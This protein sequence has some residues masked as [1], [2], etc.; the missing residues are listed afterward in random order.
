MEIGG[1]ICTAS[2]T[3]YTHNVICHTFIQS[4]S[5]VRPIESNN[6]IIARINTLRN[7]ATTCIGPSSITI[8]GVVCFHFWYETGA[9]NGSHTICRMWMMD[10]MQ[11][12]DGLHWIILLTEFRRFHNSNGKHIPMHFMRSYSAYKIHT[13]THT[14]TQMYACMA[15]ISKYSHRSNLRGDDTQ[16]KTQNNCRNHRKLLCNRQQRVSV[17]IECL[18][19]CL[20]CELYSQ[21]WQMYQFHKSYA[22]SIL[23]K[24]E[25]CLA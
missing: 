11:W 13:H 9:Y 18:Y 17:W 19:M 5:N 22:N 16:K 3:R 1:S 2:T 12:V 4:I 7:N 10:R 23:P 15:A 14:L 20:N 25:I 24:I 8:A 6:G 21:C